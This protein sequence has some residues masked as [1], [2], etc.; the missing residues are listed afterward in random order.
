MNGI[1]VNYLGAWVVRAMALG[2]TS[3]YKK[4][5]SFLAFFPADFSIAFLG[6]SNT[7]IFE[8]ELA[9]L[10]WL[11]MWRRVCC[12]IYVFGFFFS[13]LLSTFHYR[14]ITFLRSTHYSQIE[15]VTISE[16]FVLLS[17]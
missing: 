11:P 1:A 15:F 9:V 6:L 16:Y 12:E 5:L 3:Q 2:P 4:T 17:G 13:F 14:L 10:E 7:G 8:L